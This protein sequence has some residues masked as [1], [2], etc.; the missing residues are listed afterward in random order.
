MC[1]GEGGNSDGIRIGRED[2]YHSDGMSVKGVL[3]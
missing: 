3:K 1:I 2:E